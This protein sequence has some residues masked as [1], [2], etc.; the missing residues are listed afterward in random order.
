MF[1]PNDISNWILHDYCLG[2]LTVE[3]EKKVE[4]MCLTYPQVARELGLLR[5]SL[6]QFSGSDQIKNRQ[7][8]RKSVWE[9]VKKIWENTAK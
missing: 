1:N 6:E 7:Q 5:H 2:L 8:L 9:A 4:Q 3:E